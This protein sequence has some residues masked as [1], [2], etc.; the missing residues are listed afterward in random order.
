MEEKMKKTIA[1]VLILVMLSGVSSAAQVAKETTNPPSAEEM[2]F[3]V[4]LLRPLGI[5]SL[6][7][8]TVFFVVA[9]PF[10]LPSRSVGVSARRLVA[11][12]FKFTFTRPIGERPEYN[13]YDMESPGK[14]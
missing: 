11:E 5:A 9:L 1:A 4:L 2:V 3:D 6:A 12:P 14:E 13:Y 10:T 7:A 8:G